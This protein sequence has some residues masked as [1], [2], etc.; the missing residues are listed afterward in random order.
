MK[1]YN[2]IYDVHEIFIVKEQYLSAAKLQTEISS[3]YINGLLTYHDWY[4][5]EN[6]YIYLQKEL[7]DTKKKWLWQ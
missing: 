3:K 6:E 2:A 7:L 1:Y 5:A 4:A